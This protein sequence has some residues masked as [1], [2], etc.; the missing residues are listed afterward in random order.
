M[1]AA[2]PARLRYSR[3]GSAGDAI[4]AI[5]GIGAIKAHGPG[6]NYDMQG[7]LGS[8][9]RYQR[10]NDR[11]AKDH[12]AANMARGDRYNSGKEKEALVTSRD[13]TRAEGATK[14]KLSTEM[15][16]ERGK[17]FER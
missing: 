10:G 2:I 16:K 6:L 17:N 5:K 1:T 14:G 15:N 13:V 4:M 11:M 7:S 12:E 8:Q 9:A 3:A